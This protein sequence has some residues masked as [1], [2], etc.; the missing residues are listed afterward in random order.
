MKEF[1][2]RY[3]YEFALCASCFPL[4][5]SPIAYSADFTEEL[6][7]ANVSSTNETVETYTVN[8]NNISIIEFI[9]F[10][11]KISSA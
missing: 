2:T 11:S 9:R 3:W 1:R 8:F 7:A 4:I 5:Y 6:V 10:A